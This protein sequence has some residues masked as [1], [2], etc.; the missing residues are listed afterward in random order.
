MNNNYK[1]LLTKQRT[2]AAFNDSYKSKDELTPKKCFEILANLGINEILD[3][4][5]GYGTIMN[6]GWEYS[7]STYMMEV[8]LPAYLWQLMVSAENN[9]ALLFA[10]DE[11]LKRQDQWPKT[12]QMFEVSDNLVGTEGLRILCGLFELNQTILSNVLIDKVI[13]QKLSLSILLPFLLRLSTALKGDNIHIKNGGVALLKYYE[14]DYSYYLNHMLR[15]R[16][17]DIFEQHKQFKITSFEL[18]NQSIYEDA[19]NYSFPE[20]RFR[21]MLTSP[22]YPNGI[23][24]AKMYAAE[25]FFINFLFDINKLDFNRIA[26]PIIGTNVVKGRNSYNITTDVANNFLQ[27]LKTIKL[28]KVPRYAMDTYYIPYFSNYFCDLERAY[29]NISKSLEDDFVG[30]IVVTNNAIRNITIPVSDFIIE[31]WNNLGFEAK[32]VKEKEISHVGTKNPNAKGKMARHTEHIIK[33]WR[34]SFGSE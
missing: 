32:S 14:N 5:S 34:G 4:M 21:G 1:A 30:Y 7:I 20:K 9:N 29:G 19:I 11:I 3:P 10:V 27:K 28:K 22:P 13:I 18:V 2:Y 24:Y 16:L 23:D 6:Y 31:L 15:N 17:I 33:I 12:K 25:N 8:N 26:A